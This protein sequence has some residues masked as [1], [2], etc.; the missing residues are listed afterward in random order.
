VR[1]FVAP[2]GNAT[3]WTYYEGII[4]MIPSRSKA[5]PRLALPWIIRLRYATAVGQM[6]TAILVDRFLGIGLPLGWIA[7]PPMVV[8]LSNLWLARCAAKADRPEQLAESALIGWVF[9]LDTL[10]LTAVLMLSGG[11]NNPFSLLYLVHITLAA[12]ILT[13]RQTW[14]L[15]LVACLCFAL[16]FW[17]YHPIPQLEMH[18]MGDGMNLHLIGMWVGFA[19]ASLLVAFFSGKISELLREREESLLRMQ[20]ELAKKDRLA[21]LVTLAAGAAHEL[22]TPLATI[23]VVAKELERYAIEIVRNTAIAED[24]RLVRTE[25]DR[26]RAI[27][28]RMS[29]DGAEPAGEAIEDVAVQWIVDAVRR[30]VSALGLLRVQMVKADAGNILR[31]PRHAVE[32]ALIALVKNA[33]E[34]SPRAVPVDLTVVS[35]A[36]SVRFAVQDRGCGMNAE[37]LRHAG[38]PFFT[39]KEPGKGMGLGIFLVRTL[40]DRLGGRLVLESSLGKGTS[41]ALDLPLPQIVVS[42]SRL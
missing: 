13:R 24:S 7:V 20:E 2:A 19:I 8:A 12:A 33:F 35:A 38:E 11:P 31:L 1:L 27:L 15:G 30:E 25:V 40:A 41:A 32:Q 5:A 22:S 21:A 10:C 17:R 23:A 4:A 37:A 6:S 26:C 29:T 39:T 28:T 42:T 18:R 34:A 9:L 14:C 16:L 3:E 36:D